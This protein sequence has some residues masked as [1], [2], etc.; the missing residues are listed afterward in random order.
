MASFPTSGDDVIFGTSADETIEALGGNDTVFGLGGN[1]KLFGGDGNDALNGSTGNNNLSGGAGIDTAYYA[2][3]I[4]S[5]DVSLTRGWGAPTG[6]G[7]DNIDFYI[8]IENIEGGSANDFLTGNRGQNFIDGNGGEDIIK[9]G[10]GSDALSGGADDDRLYGS[11]GSDIVDGGSGNDIVSGGSGGDLLI[12][13]DG[14]DSLDY[15]ESLLGV[16]IDLA[17]NIAHGGDA[18]GDTI[19]GFEEISGSNHG[20]DLLGSSVRNFIWAG[21]EGDEIEGRGGNDEIYGWGGEDNIL[22]GGGTDFIEGGGGADNMQGGAGGDWFSYRGITDSGLA[23]GE[24]DVILDFKQGDDRISFFSLFEGEGVF[25]GTDGF[26]DGVINQVRY[27]GT[28]SKTIVLVDIDGLN[29]ADLKIDMTGAFTLT[30]G[31]FDM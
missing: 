27:S 5:M 23:V 10:S 9:G 16:V 13:G 14:V 1:D 24:R 29:G 6:Q 4:V 28:S 8:S 31:D 2:L 15:S 25:R 3:S 7:V 26:L 20:D 22:G 18:E 30:A 19:S 12:G 11:T 17:A 21:N